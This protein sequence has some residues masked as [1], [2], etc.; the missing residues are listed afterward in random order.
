LKTLSANDVEVENWPAYPHKI[1]VVL[2]QAATATDVSFNVCK[3]SVAK[4][5]V[6]QKCG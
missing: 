5:A 6:Q 2:C 4:F 3:A 1:N